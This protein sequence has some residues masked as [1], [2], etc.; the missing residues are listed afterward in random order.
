MSTLSGVFFGGDKRRSGPKNIIW[1]VEHGHQAAISIDNY[2]QGVPA[3]ERPKAG[4]NLISQKMGLSEWSYHNDFNPASR[5]K[6]SHVDLAS[7]FRQLEIEVELGFDP[8]QTA[9]EVQRLPELRCR[10]GVRQPASDAS[11]ATPA[12]I[13]ARCCA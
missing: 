12:S 1:A 7:R 11:S 5:Q 13:F 3:T 10:N 6:M 8:E 2:C 4:M 9:R